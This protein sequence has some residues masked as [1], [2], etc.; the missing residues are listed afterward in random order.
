MPAKS[1]L[2]WPQSPATV[3]AKLY[4]SSGFA[5]TV[6]GMSGQGSIDF[7]N[8]DPTRVQ[9]PSFS[10]NA[11]GGV[12]TVTDGSHSAN[13]ALIGNYLAAT[14]VASSDSNGGTSVADPQ[15]L[16]GVARLSRHRTPDGRGMPRPPHPPCLKMSGA[17]RRATHASPLRR[18]FFPV[19]PACYPPPFHL[20][21]GHKALA[22]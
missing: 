13:V 15:L 4:D 18:A 11:S 12:L 2:S 3:P 1:M 10:G 17:A 22:Q 19:P 16:G 5:G 6:A 7:A 21:G 20:A 14:F 9:P 8:I